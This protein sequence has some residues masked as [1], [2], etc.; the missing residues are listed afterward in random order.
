MQRLLFVVLFV[1]CCHSLTFAQTSDPGQYPKV[2]GFVG[3]SANGYFANPSSITAVN[4]TISSFFS[5][6][7]GGNKGF[8]TSLSRS[9]NKYVGLKGDLSTYFNHSSGRAGTLCVNDDCS[10][11]EDFNVKSRAF[12]LMGGPEI[13]A[14]NHTR[15]TPFAHSLFGLARSRSE[16]KTINSSFDYADSHT[17]TGFAMALGG[18]FDIRTAGRFSIRSLIDYVPTSLG[19]ADPRE[20]GRQ[21]HVRLS[22]GI[23]FH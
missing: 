18:G 1:V 9:L 15:L 8:E 19:D 5:D 14:R 2:E 17:R 3:Y 13:K 11:G 22:V 7:A 10:T 12:Y 4:Q 21:K 23:L 20:S 16:F 6:Q